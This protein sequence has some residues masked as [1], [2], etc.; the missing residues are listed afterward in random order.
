VTGGLQARAQVGVDPEE[1]LSKLASYYSAYAE[2]P[3]T[4]LLAEMAS[5]TANNAP[6]STD[7]AYLSSA[8]SMLSG[9]STRLR[10]FISMTEGN[11]D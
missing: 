1:Y 11:H 6:S 2:A 7:A 8:E 9:E 5:Y 3:G 10:P 4:S